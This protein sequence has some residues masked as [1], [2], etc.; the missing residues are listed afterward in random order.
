MNESACPAPEGQ[1]FGE[2]LGELDRIVAELEGGQLELEESLLRY[3]RGVALLRGLQAKLAD[4][5]QK[6]T[7]L[8]GELESEDDDAGTE[9]APDSDSG[10]APA[11]PAT[12][13][14]EVPF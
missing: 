5:Q 13:D 14:E 3:E 1:S 4:A 6:V 9:S 2:A 8:M 11:A 10:S 7:L 12:R